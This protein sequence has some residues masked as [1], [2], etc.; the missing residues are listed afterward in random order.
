MFLSAMQMIVLER[1]TLRPMVC[2]FFIFS[3]GYNLVYSGFLKNL[4]RAGVNKWLDD[5]TFYLNGGL[6][7][8]YGYDYHGGYGRY[9]NGRF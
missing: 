9:N 4:I 2:S 7:S 1:P 8:S 6:S 5:A 3:I